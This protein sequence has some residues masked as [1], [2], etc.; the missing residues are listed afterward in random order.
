MVG[1]N[2]ELGG[3]EVATRAFYGPDDTTDFEVEGGRG[4][5]VAE[6]GAADEEDGVDGTVKLFLLER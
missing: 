4:W 3:P 5:F 6:G 1:V 2:K